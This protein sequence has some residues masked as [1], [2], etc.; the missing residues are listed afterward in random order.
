MIT[1]IAWTGGTMKLPFKTLTR[2]DK[3]LVSEIFR[4]QAQEYIARWGSME[5]DIAR[6]FWM[7]ARYTAHAMT[8]K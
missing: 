6:L 4:E 8:R 7:R 3:Y 1:A 5:W 2:R